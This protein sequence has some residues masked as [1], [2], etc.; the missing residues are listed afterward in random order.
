MSVGG[1]PGGDSVGRAKSRKPVSCA[2]AVL[3]SIF[4]T[5]APP[6][7]ACAR[8]YF[9][10]RPIRKNENGLSLTAV[11]LP[12]LNKNCPPKPF[13]SRAPFYTMQERRDGKNFALG[14]Y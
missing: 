8:L 11:F 10:R 14:Q 5:V 13:E 3:T 6:R 4:L 9:C 12:T 1:S 2:V 7:R